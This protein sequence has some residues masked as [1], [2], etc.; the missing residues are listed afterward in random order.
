MSRKAV[1][2]GLL[3]RL[4]VLIVCCN[5]TPAP[6]AGPY[7]MLQHY[8][9]YN[10]YAYTSRYLYFPFVGG[11][12]YPWYDYRPYYGWSIVGGGGPYRANAQSSP[13]RAS[14]FHAPDGPA[15]AHVTLKVP[16]D[17]EVWFDGYKTRATGAV[18]EFDTPPLTHGY[19]Y[20]YQV[21]ARWQQDGRTVTQDREVSLT[22]GSRVAVA[23]PPAGEAKEP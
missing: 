2:F 10:P 3:C 9:Y 15:A 19:R 22:A 1:L 16:A 5:A 11:G 13:Q 20:T 14:G 12:A 21:R 18:R 8:G 6:A 4:A 23:I 17:A 7:L